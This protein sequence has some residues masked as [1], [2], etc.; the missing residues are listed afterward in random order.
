MYRRHFIQSFALATAHSLSATSNLHSQTKPRVFIAGAGLAGLSA[1]YELAKTGHA[2][3]VIEARL[4]PGG[5]VFTLRDKFANGSYVETG[6]ETLADGYKRFVAYANEFGLPFD[7]GDAR[8]R[9][10][11]LMKGQLF[12]ANQPIAPHPYGLK[13]KEGMAPP[14]LLAAHLREMGEEVRL[15][16]SKLMAFDQMS[17]AETLRKRGASAQAIQLMEVSLN[18]NDIE[19]V[20][21]GG[22]LFEAQRRTSGGSK[23]IRLRGGNSRLVEALAAAVEKAGAQILYGTQLIKVTHSDPTVR[24][25]VINANGSVANFTADHFI[26]ALPATTLQ[27][28]GFVPSLPAAKTRSLEN[29]P[30]TRVTKVFLQ[31]RRAKWDEAQLGAGMWTDTGLERVIAVPMNA[32]LNPASSR[33]VFTVWLDGKGA[34]QPDLFNDA[35]RITWAKRAAAKHLP[36]LNE[37]IEGATTVSWANDPWA[38]GAYM[39]FLT[40]QLGLRQELGTPVG[41]L[42]FAGEH[43]AETSPGM[44]GALESGLRVAAEISGK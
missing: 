7:E 25:T 11:T 23:I 4:R 29:L 38:R 16:A 5:R 17:L 43:T 14:E 9:L 18:Y 10:G 31:A 39:H 37:Q 28:V 36:V 6:G 15:D 13:D 20:S 40:G 19:Q 32:G 44:E 2:V 34:E 1:A 12:R 21:A 22:V 8:R 41:K 24:A 35:E 33:G 3:T 26:S 27:R 42:H 30:Y